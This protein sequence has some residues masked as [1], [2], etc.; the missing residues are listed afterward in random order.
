VNIFRL[1]TG[2]VVAATGGVLAIVVHVGGHIIS[3]WRID[4]VPWTLLAC[5]GLGFVLGVLLGP[6]TLPNSIPPFR[7]PAPDNSD[8]VSRPT[9][10]PVVEITPE[11]LA[12]KVRTIIKDPQIEI[13]PINP[14][15][16]SWNLRVRKEELDMEYVWFGSYG[17]GGTDLARPF[18]EDD[19]PFS[20]AD[21]GFQS[22]DEGLEYLR[23]LA[24]KYSVSS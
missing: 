17:F 6:R 11:E 24:R 8:S 13:A 19:N 4:L 15:Y 9:N 5:A 16:G 1:W 12:A 23:K 7:L 14:E 2:I 3:G 18:T 20:L 22:I 10:S 21:E